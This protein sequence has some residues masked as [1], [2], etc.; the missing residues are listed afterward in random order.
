MPG[1]AHVYYTAIFK[2]GKGESGT[3]NGERERGIFKMRNLK[4]GNL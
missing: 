2:T 4:S 3:G 1:E